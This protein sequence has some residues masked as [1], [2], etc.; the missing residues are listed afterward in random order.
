M[1]RDEY[2]ESNGVVAIGFSK[3]NNREK[4]KSQSTRG[5]RR[6]PINSGDDKHSKSWTLPGKFPRRVAEDGQ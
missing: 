5:L 4:R 1:G 2:T 3:A 6:I